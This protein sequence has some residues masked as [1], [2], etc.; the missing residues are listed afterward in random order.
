MQR[1]GAKKQDDYSDTRMRHRS[2]RDSTAPSMERLLAAIIAIAD[3]CSLRLGRNRSTAGRPALQRREPGQVRKEAAIA[4]NCKCRGNGSPPLA[5]CS[6]DRPDTLSLAR[7]NA[8]L[9][10]CTLR[11]L[12][13]SRLASGRSACISPMSR[14]PQTD[15]KA[16]RRRE[17]ARYANT[18]GLISNWW[19][20]TTDNFHWRLL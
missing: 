3:N 20:I 15:L 1:G 18:R 10:R 2:R 6:P 16:K 14:T 11:V 17:F 13:V 12:A 8:H 19:R 9:L 4:D 7:W 5:L